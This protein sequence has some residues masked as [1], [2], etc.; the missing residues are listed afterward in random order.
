MSKHRHRT[1]IASNSEM[2]Y[3]FLGRKIRMMSKFS[4]VIYLLIL[5][6]VA[7][8]Q[9]R[10]LIT[11]DIDITPPGRIE[12]AAGADFYQ[13]A[14]FPLSGIKGDLTR[15]GDV[16]VRTGYAGNVE[17]SV[18]G[19]IQDFL[20]INSRDPNPPIPL[21]IDENSSTDFG[22]I[23]TRVKI[24]LSNETESLPAF[25]FSVGFKTPNSD[26]SR[27]IGTN[28]IEIY[29]RVIAQKTFG[30]EPGQDPRAKVFGNV[31]LGILNSPLGQF[32]QNDVILYGLAGVFRVNKSMNL[33]S[34]VNGQI[35]T[36]GNTTPLG[37]ESRGQFRIGTQIKASGLRFDT[38]AIFGLNRYSPQS[39][40]TFGVTY[41][42]PKI[43]TP[44]Q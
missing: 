35:S 8:G 24:K 1:K 38:A 34:E 26:Q 40:V 25:G 18:E 9:T 33:A 3:S 7:S 23:V 15:V 4:L 5:T 31:G 16:R 22:D 17:V 13:D 29:T 32:S 37:T 6:V 14:K 28:Q 10:P 44:A 2:P 27:A 43:F 12:I 39:G 36:R 30:K 19:V 21:R 42:S 11:E 41:L 20:A